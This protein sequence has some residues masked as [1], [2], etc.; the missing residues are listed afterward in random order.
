[1]L[2]QLLA[3]EGRAESALTE[4]GRVLR[5][6]PEHV[7]AHLLASRLLAESGN[8]A[9]AERQL[10]AALKHEPESVEA[11]TNL[12][13]VLAMRGKL[14]DAIEALRQSLRLSDDPDTHFNLAAVFEQRGHW[15]EAR[16]HYQQA[17]ELAPAFDAA[18]HRLR[19]LDLR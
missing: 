4:C 1:M 8:P 9:A 2:A 12:G 17:L 18:R 10:R 15:N 16:S 3:D 11:Q 14:D 13:I 7:D 5:I 6:A 19:D